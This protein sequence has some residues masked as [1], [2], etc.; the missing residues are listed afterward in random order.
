M[1]ITEQFDLLTV[2]DVWTHAD[3]MLS[4]YLRVH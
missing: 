3:K 1:S 4:E 2:D